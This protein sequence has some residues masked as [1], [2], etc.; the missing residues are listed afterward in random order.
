[1][2]SASAAAQVRRFGF[3]DVTALRPAEVHA[4]GGLRIT[5]TVGAPVPAVENGYQLDHPCG[6]PYL[7]PHGFLAEELPSRSLDAVITPVIDVGLPLAGALV[8]GQQVLPRLLERFQLLTVLASSTGGDVRFE[9][10]L[11][12][13]LRLEGSVQEAEALVTERGAAFGCLLLDP[14]P[15]TCYVAAT[16]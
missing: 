9:G 1:V 3:L 5:A 13:F 6:S 2:A 7:E 15:G 11:R 14:V 12:H 8:K 16:R 4:Q 10:L